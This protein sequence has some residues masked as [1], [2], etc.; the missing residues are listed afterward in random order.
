MASAVASV[1]SAVESKDEPKVATDHF[2]GPVGAVGLT[3]VL[4]FLVMYLHATVAQ[5]GGS[6]WLPRST[7]ELASMIP[8]PTLR[9]AT[10]YFAWFALHAVLFSFAPGK[11]VEGATLR[12]G[13]RL[14]YRLNGLASLVVSVGILVGLMA[15]G[16]LLP[17]AIVAEIGPMITI[18]T[19]LTVG[20]SV[21]FYF[22]GRA[23]GRQERSSS[24]VPYDFFMGTILNPRLRLFDFKFFLEGRMGMASWGALAVVL[25]WAEY[26]RYGHVSLAMGVV[27]LCQL[28]YIVDFFVF[29]S[30]LL[31]M[32][33]IIYE[34]FGFMLVFGCVVWIPFTFAL[35]QQYLLVQ[36]HALPT[37]A[38]VAIVVMHLAGYV[39]FR[40]SNLQKQRFRQDPSKNVWGKP[41]KFMET[42]RG[43]KL[44]LSGW[45]GLSRHSNYM[46][47][48][49]MALS[50]C[51]A[52]G[53]S[54]VVPY[55]YFLYF[56][57][58][59][60]NRERRDHALCK[61]KYGADWDEYCKRVP[62]RIVPFVF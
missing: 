20:F 61:E 17:S 7:A 9:A 37:L 11:L 22:W 4:P 55:F 8:L 49:T 53:F 14:Q 46:G 44:L 16:T 51:L 62:W 47:D 40:D 6:L 18:S 54:H 41:P 21:W 31:S 60:V 58:L 15:T 23:R 48:L 35:Q 2:G 24:N 57:P 30:N 39:V 10:I 28:W 43:T 25:P 13:T 56:A 59:L 45:W 36:P 38:A 34:N 3:F 12:D 5:H 1:A 33:D 27:T 19:L 26:E 32:L 29:E 50:W 42:K 52:C